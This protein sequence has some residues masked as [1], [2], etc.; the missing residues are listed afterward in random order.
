MHSSLQLINPDILLLFASPQLPPG[1][2][3]AEEAYNF[4]T[5]TFDPEPEELE[6]NPKA[7]HTE[8]ANQEEVGEEEGPP[9]QGVNK[10][11]SNILMVMMMMVMTMRTTMMMRMMRMRMMM[12]IR[13]K[14]RKWMTMIP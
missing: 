9:V 5:F 1:F 4:F 3:S 13:R 2:P 8:G 14:R 7:K 10:T 11:V 12:L 6:E